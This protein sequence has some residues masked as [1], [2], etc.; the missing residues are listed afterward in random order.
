MSESFSRSARNASYSP[1]REARERLLDLGGGNPEG[2]QRRGVHSQ[3][4]ELFECQGALAQASQ[5]RA[6]PPLGEDRSA[7]EALGRELRG[8][9]REVFHQHRTPFVLQ[10]G[11]ELAQAAERLIS[12]GRTAFH[13]GAESLHVAGPLPAQGQGL[14]L[15]PRFHVPSMLADA[16]AFLGHHRVHRHRGIPGVRPEI[17]EPDQ[18]EQEE[19]QRRGGVPRD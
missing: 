5:E 7:R 11:I 4:L 1:G 14:P 3:H 19:G 16:R 10:R 8:A 18:P 6:E 17:H 12:R 9:G 13:S 15:R 2:G